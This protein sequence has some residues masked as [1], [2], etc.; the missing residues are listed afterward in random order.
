MQKNSP[1]FAEF[2]PVDRKEW[3]AKIEKD[4]KGKAIEALNWEPEP[5]WKIPPLFHHT[6]APESSFLSD[7]RSANQWT[8]G[9]LIMVKDLKETNQRILTCLQGGANA[10][11]LHLDAALTKEQLD[12]LLKDVIPSY[13]QLHFSW[14]TAEFPILKLWKAIQAHLQGKGTSSTAWQGSLHWTPDLASEDLESATQLLQH[15]GDPKLQLFYIK[16]QAGTSSSMAEELAGLIQQGQAYLAQL[17][18][19]GI[20]AQISAP[21]IQFGISTRN[22]F[23]VEI[24]RIRALKILWANV[25]KAYELDDY[26]IHIAV[27]TAAP[28]SDDDPYRLMIQ[29]ATQAM[30]A[31]IGGAN[32]LFV[33]SADQGDSTRDSRFIDNPDFGPRIAR[34]VQHLLQLESFMDRVIDPGAGSYY[35]E[36]LTQQLAAKAWELFQ[37]TCP[38]A[39]HC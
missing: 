4:L 3:M 12:L 35:I 39:W 20:N 31:V 32:T 5:G 26:P 28:Q 2:S 14:T 36:H 1:L 37:G 16:D 8:I 33:L 29:A 17:Q 22:T 27:R 18:E 23:F 13:I 34:N 6:D 7:Q 11:E 19:V 24:A 38:V 9:Q 15:K 30:S 10:L 21:Y 25:L